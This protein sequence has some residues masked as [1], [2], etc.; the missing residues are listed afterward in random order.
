MKLVQ[1]RTDIRRNLL[2]L[3]GYRTFQ[4]RQSQD[5]FRTTIRDGICFVL[6][7][8]SGR[9][10]FGPSR[11]IGYY[12]NTMPKH[13]ANTSKHGSVTNRRIEQLLGTAFH[14]SIS[15]ETKFMAFCRRYS[16]TPQH[17]RRKYI[18]LSEEIRPDDTDLLQGD[19]DEIDKDQ[20]LT[21]TER[22]R[23][24]LARIGQGHFRRQV[25]RYWSRCPMTGCGMQVLLRA[26]HIK[27]WRDCSNT[28]RLDG[29]NGLLLAPQVDL[30]FD[31]GLISFDSQG[32]ILLSRS[33]PVSEAKKL[34]L[35]IHLHVSFSPK[36]H[37]Y[38][39]HHRK[40]V[41]IG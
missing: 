27:P 20:R 34:G 29:Y 5:L 37:K 15:T 14:P 3:D 28:E 11:F 35:K 19:I 21:A 32:H 30:A 4:D 1:N 26:S 6:C 18:Y 16:I 40:H 31:R 25:Q 7:E 12:R 24:A 33:L 39:E 41:F 17:R 36:H 8:V 13:R 23:L 9:V 22:K 2:T 10:L 38:L